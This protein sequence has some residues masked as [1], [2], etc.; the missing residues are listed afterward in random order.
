MLVPQIDAG[1]EGAEGTARLPSNADDPLGLAVTDPL[2]AA[3]FTSK[4]RR[5]SSDR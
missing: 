3:V 4:L 2:S 1:I 5:R